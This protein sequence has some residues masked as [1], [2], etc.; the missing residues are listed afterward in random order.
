MAAGGGRAGKAAAA[1]REEEAAASDGKRRRRRRRA[2]F[3]PSSY[4]Y[5]RASSLYGGVRQVEREKETQHNIFHVFFFFFLFLYP[6][7]FKIR[8]VI[9]LKWTDNSTASLPRLFP[10]PQVAIKPIV[11]ILQYHNFK[12][13]A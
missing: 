4:F 9:S 10:R 6:S 12:C 3:L 1:A 8:S 7:F 2:L 13:S 11:F 5:N